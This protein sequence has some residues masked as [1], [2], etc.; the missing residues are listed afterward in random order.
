MIGAWKVKDLP[1]CT[2]HVFLSHCAEDRARLVLPVFQELQNAAYSPWIDQHHYPAGQDA[3][4]AL[5]EGIVRCRH[6][7]YFV[8]AEYLRQ[9]RGWN[10]IENA[11]SNLLQANLHDR[12]LELCHIQFPLVFLPKSHPTL[13]RS[14]WGPLVHR[15]RFY[16][17]GRVDGAAVGW[18]TQQIIDF[19]KQE[20]KRG[21]DLAIQVQHDPGFHPLLAAEPNLLRR[22]MCADPPPVP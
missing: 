8:T 21:A 20:E 4:E 5:R 3:C 13:A 12:G 7:V 16:S 18:A 17:P 9:G 22:V 10:S 6:V 11:Y 15:A 1:R 14:A 19:I 2:H